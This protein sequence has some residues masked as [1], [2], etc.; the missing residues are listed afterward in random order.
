MRIHPSW[1]IVP[2]QVSQGNYLLVSWSHHMLFLCGRGVYM[3]PMTLRKLLL[4]E[5]IC[6]YDETGNTAWTL[7]LNLNDYF[8]T[9]FSLQ[10]DL[11]GCNWLQSALVWPEAN[12]VIMKSLCWIPHASQVF[13]SPVQRW[14]CLFH[15]SCCLTI[16]EILTVPVVNVYMYNI[17]RFGLSCEHPLHMTSVASN[18]LSKDV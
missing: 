1:K 3:A 13:F 7:Y 2:A 8:P 6:T 18:W 17:Q 12:Q 11:P 4:I 9:V 15:I 14:I 10:L 5:L 16:W